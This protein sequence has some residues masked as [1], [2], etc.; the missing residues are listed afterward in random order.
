MEIDSLFKT[1]NI[2]HANE[3]AHSGFLKAAINS[4]FT[5]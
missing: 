2:G 5:N 4:N 3:I 1:F